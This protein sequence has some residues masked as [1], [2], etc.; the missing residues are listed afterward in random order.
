VD[1]PQVVSKFCQDPLGGVAGLLPVPEGKK[2]LQ[3]GL[4]PLRTP[5]KNALDPYK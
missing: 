3:D 4:F 5:L 1:L 2:P